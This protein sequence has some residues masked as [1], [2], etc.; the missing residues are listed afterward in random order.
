M[1]SERFTSWGCA[2]PEGSRAGGVAGQAQEQVDA[3]QLGCPQTLPLARGAQ[4]QGGRRMLKCFTPAL[5][6]KIFMVL[7]FP[8]TLQLQWTGPCLSVWL[9]WSTAGNMTFDSL[10]G[11]LT[12]RFPSMVL[13][14]P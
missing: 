13:Y 8:S 12:G 3:L 10:S 4:G 9:L 11:G 14:F 7:Y 5:W 2:P 1:G 6:G